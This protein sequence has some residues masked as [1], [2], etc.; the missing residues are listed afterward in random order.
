MDQ[1]NTGL[2]G[3]PIPQ[4]AVSI[5]G[6]TG[7]LTW[8]GYQFSYTLPITLFAGDVGQQWP[9]SP[10]WGNVLSLGASETTLGHG[11]PCPVYD[12]TNG[13][14]TVT[15]TDGT[16]WVHAIPDTTDYGFDT[17]ISF[18]VHVD[19]SA[20]DTAG[21]GAFYRASLDF[22]VVYD[23]TGAAVLYPATPTATDVRSNGPTLA[24]EAVLV[25]NILQVNVQ[26]A[27]STTHNWSV[28]GKARA[29]S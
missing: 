26:G 15:T 13:S 5:P 12:F 18:D 27:A 17:A 7:F 4:V 3:Q 23:S 11:S 6:P 16:T 24:V 19:L 21:G 25:S 22:T 28:S 10:S 2:W 29:V 9:P 1:M 20:I 14:M 8:D